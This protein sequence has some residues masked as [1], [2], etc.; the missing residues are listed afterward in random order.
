MPGSP[1]SNNIILDGGTLRT[2]AQINS[3]SLT[4]A[5]SGY[6]SFPTLTIGGAG[7][8][9]HRRLRQCA[10]RDQ[11]H[12]RHQRRQRVRQSDSGIAARGQHRRHVRRHRRRRRHRRDGVRH[13]LRRRRHRHHDHQP[14]QRLHLDA[15]DPYFVNHQRA[16]TFAGSGATANVSG[17][18]LQ[19]IA[20]NDGGFDYTTPTISLTGGGGSGATASA[21][22]SPNFTLDSNRGIELTANGGTLYQTAGTTF[23]V[24]GPI[25]STGNGLLTKNGAGTLILNGA[26]TYSGGTSVTSGKLDLEGAQTSLGT[27]N[28]S[29][30]GA[31]LLA[32][33]FEPGN[34][35]NRRCR[36]PQHPR[37]G[38]REPE[39]RN[40]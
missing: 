12:R 35:C 39:R 29:V 33:N 10:G 13:R 6:T 32:G 22:P 38:H 40:Q 21:T 30:S 20:L 31:G 26:N 4:N 28:V 7:A 24:D 11:L 14:G 27:G 5:G 3:V 2:G 19:S 36:Q 25:S 1:Q 17:I 16:A 18:T 8:N 9:V 34:Q 23:T 37:R 15:D